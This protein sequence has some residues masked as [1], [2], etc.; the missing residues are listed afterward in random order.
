MLDFSEPAAA[1][2]MPRQHHPPTG[3][4][5]NDEDDY[6]VWVT[7]RTTLHSPTRGVVVTAAAAAGAEG[8]LRG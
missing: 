3:S 5:S 2:V 8:C 4:A 7:L 1:R 6:N